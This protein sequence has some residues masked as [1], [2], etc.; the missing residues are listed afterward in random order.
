MFALAS[1]AISASHTAVVRS[2]DGVRLRAAAPD[3]AS[4][5]AQLVAYI[6]GRYDHTLW[7]AA[8]AEVRALLEAGR[9]DEAVAAYFA[10]VGQ[11]WDEEHLER[12][13]PRS[14]VARGD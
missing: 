1:T 3:P 14:S 9:S 11:R 8:A 12:Y 10:H 4:L 5:T 6:R 2:A 7:P 13:A